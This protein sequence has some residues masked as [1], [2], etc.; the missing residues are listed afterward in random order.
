MPGNNETSSATKQAG[1]SRRR[2]RYVF[3][4]CESLSKR[5]R[6]EN[7]VSLRG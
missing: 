5:P 3:P 7:A 1:A 6:P 4:A 2:Y